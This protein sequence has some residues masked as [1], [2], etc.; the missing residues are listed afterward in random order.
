MPRLFVALVALVVLVSCGSGAP[1]ASETFT[2]VA[3]APTEASTSTLDVAPTPTLIPPTTTPVSTSTVVPTQTSTALAVGDDVRR[4]YATLL[5]LGGT[6][7]A[8]QSTAQ[9]IQSEKTSGFEALGGQ[10]AIGGFLRVVGDTFK[11][12]SPA[13]AFDEVWQQSQNVTTSV[14][15][16][17]RQWLDKKITATD[18][19]TALG[20]IQEQYDQA[21][22]S[23]VDVLQQDYGMSREQVEAFQ[24]EVAEDMRKRMEEAATPADPQT[25]VAT[26]EAAV[27]TSADV[28]FGKPLVIKLQG[29]EMSQVYIPVTNNGTTVKSFTAKAT[30]KNGDQIAATASGAINDL[31]AGQTRALSLHAMEKLPDNGDAPKIEVDTMIGEAA[32]T[33]G[34]AAAKKVTFGPP[35][36]SSTAGFTQLDVEVTNGDDKPHSLT[37]QAVFMKGDELVAV[38]IGAVNDVAPGQ[39]KT[40]TLVVQGNTEDAEPKVMVDTLMQ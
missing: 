35:K 22:K 8:L 17:Y 27:P 30:W 23:S 6:I 1:A 21:L 20:P 2:A 5:L 37:V 32:S 38:G 26:Q 11:N 15:D 16:L 36:V 28:V 33:P 18:V 24:K 39:T 13:P 12:P 25:S 10:I 40:A 29:T 7:G 31:Q 9:E 34:A 19:L 14:S 3:E 4:A